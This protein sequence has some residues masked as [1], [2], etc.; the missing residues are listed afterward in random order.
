MKMKIQA[1]CITCCKGDV[2]LARICVASVRYW[3]PDVPIYLIKDFTQGN[4]STDSMEKN[5]RVQQR[6]HKD[7]SLGWGFV[8]LAGFFLKENSRIL[9]L[10]CDIVVLGKVLEALEAVGGDFIVA[11]ERVTSPQDP[12]IKK[13]YF[14]YDTLKKL[15]PDFVFGGYCFNGGQI[16]AKTGILRKEDFDPF[17]IWSKPIALKYPKIFF[18][19]DQGLLNYL[20][21]K[22]SQ[23]N[24]ATVAIAD[25]SR[26]GFSDEIEKY[27][28]D[29]IKRH[30]GYPLIIHWAGPKPELIQ[31]MPRGDILEFFENYYYRGSPSERILRPWRHLRL[32]QRTVSRHLRSLVKQAKG[33]FRRCLQVKG[34]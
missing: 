5:W 12:I 20:L 23:R 14:D 15:D 33:I 29:A 21:Q 4:F 16:V 17:V 22:K 3:Y 13:H 9:I 2:H 18:Q 11:G 6:S 10:D 7:L 8:K 31:R 32:R 1:V 25:F 30:E 24:E 28:L 26:W 19:G 34:N 27:S